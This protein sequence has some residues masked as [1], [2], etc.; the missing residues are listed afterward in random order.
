MND[1]KHADNISAFIK[2]WLLFALGQS[3]PTKYTPQDVAKATVTAFQRTL[4]A[5]VPG[6][7][8]LSGGQ[9]EEEASVNL[10]A[11]NQYPGMSV[12]G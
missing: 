12:F 3:C 11:I 9:S 5:A 6:V 7:V 1:C 10:N 8:F 2:S 4:P